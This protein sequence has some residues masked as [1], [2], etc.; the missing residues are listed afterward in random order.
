M[1]GRKELEQL[2][3]E[4]R[5]HE[6]AY[7]AGRPEIP[8]SAF[9]DLVDRYEEVADALGIDPSQR[10]DAQLGQEHTAGFETV[11]HRMPMLSLEKLSPNRRDS[12]GEPMPIGSSRGFRPCIGAKIPGRCFGRRQ[13]SNVRRW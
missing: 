2:T 10:L 5:Y 6:A 13:S 12:S 8:D 7:R 11:E 1:G 9:D 4:I 3:E